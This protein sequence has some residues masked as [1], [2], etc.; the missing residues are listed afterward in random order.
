MMG[1]LRAC[2]A[3]KF[4]SK[5]LE[6]RKKTV[7]HPHSWLQKVSNIHDCLHLYQLGLCRSNHL[8]AND[9]D[10][11]FHDSINSRV[12]RV[13]NWRG[14]F[15]RVFVR[16]LKTFYCSVCDWCVTGFRDHQNPVHFC[17]KRTISLYVVRITLLSC[18]RTIS[19]VHA[20]ISFFGSSEKNAKVEENF[21][22]L[23]TSSLVFC[24]RIS[25]LPYLQ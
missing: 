3:G 6:Q 7:E 1:S 20:S 2:P 17:R 5:H 19:R 15:V 10:R 4:S 16:H 13:Y 14:K 18:K 8:D 12:V 25:S 24:G 9:N 11:E 23:L 21:I 22:W